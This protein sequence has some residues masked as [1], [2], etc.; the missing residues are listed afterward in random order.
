MNP[1]NIESNTETITVSA[2]TVETEPSPSVKAQ[3]AD[4]VDQAKAEGQARVQ[5]IQDILK[6]AF[7]DTLSE[8]K[9][10]SR[11]V[12]NISKDSIATVL[13]I[14][15][16]ELKQPEIKTPKTEIPVVD[17]SVDIGVH[18][19][20][21]VETQV[22]DPFWQTVLN[23]VKTK[24]QVYLK[25]EYEHLPDRLSPLQEKA[26]RWDRELGEKYGDRYTFTKR[27]SQ[28]VAKQVFAKA[29]DWYR[30]ATQNSETPQSTP[31]DRRQIE[32]EL[33]VTDAGEKL[34]QK[35]NQIK[36]QLKETVKSVL[37]VR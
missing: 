12:W 34:A 1:N 11:Q 37:K 31:L 10:G 29:A 27:T 24:A 19:D 26:A 4:H 20:P 22:V 33:V 13:E 8:L 16:S 21:H 18:A 32:I 15:T 30:N 25:Q 3:I 23:S 6:T 14:E 5:R 35:E 2:E 9:G 36:Q 28:N 17:A 7:A